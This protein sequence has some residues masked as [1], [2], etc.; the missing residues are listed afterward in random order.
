MAVKERSYEAFEGTGVTGHHYAVLLVL[1]EG[2][3]ETQGTIADAL[4]YDRSVLVGLLDELEELGFVKR[5]RDPLDRR[6][7][8][9][10]LTP[11]GA[12]AISRLRAI[13]ERVEREFL[14]PL[15]DAERETLRELLL[16]LISHHDP[17]CA[18]VQAA[19]A[20]LTQP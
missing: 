8:V 4:S 1:E 7:H 5:Q 3:R 2:A 16:K 19:A 13:S 20:P 18:L 9:V 12:E 17:R 15:D 11:A 14:V 10:S 6:R